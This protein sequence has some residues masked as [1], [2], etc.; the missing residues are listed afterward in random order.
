MPI[1][2]ILSGDTETYWITHQ[3]LFQLQKNEIKFK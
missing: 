2:R 1:T 3:F